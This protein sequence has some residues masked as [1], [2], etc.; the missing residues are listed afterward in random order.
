MTKTSHDQLKLAANTVRGLTMDAVEKANSG[1]PGMPM[2]MADAAV[3]LWLEHL[4]YSPADPE[5][6]GRDRFVLSAGH[7][8][9]LL[10]SLLHLAGY[11]LDLEQ[12]K[13]FRQLHSRTPG[14]PEHGE[15]VG[16]ET[17]TGPL[18]QGFGNGVGMALAARMEAAR[19]SCSLLETRVFGI[20]SDGDLMEGVA[21]EAASIAGHLGLSNLV[22][23]YDDNRITIDGKTEITFSEDVAQRFEG[24]G[25]RVL[26]ADGHDFDSVR[27][28]LDAAIA[29]SRKP[30]LIVCR[31]HI[32]QG[33]PNKANTSGAHG[34][35]LGA[36]EVAATK[37]A[38]GLP[39]QAFWVPDE[40]RKLFAARAKTNE[41]ARRGWNEKLEQW[42][43]AHADQ[44]ALHARF[45]ERATPADLLEQLVGAVG[46][47]ADA[48][49]NLSGAVI[50]KAADLVPSLVGGAADLDSS[51]K[52]RI[53]ASGA[54]TRDDYAGRNIHFGVREHGM[55]AILNGMALQGG[56]LP[57]GSTFLVFSDYM[58]PSIRL[59]ALM[60][61]PITFV[62]THDSLMLGED[63]PTHQP[64]EHLA[65]L[66]LIPNLHVFRPADGPEVAA[67]WAHALR[68]RDGPV[69]MALTR[70]TVPPL[71]RPREFRSA[72][73]L[74]GGYTVLETGPNPCAV[75]VA[76]GAEVHVT[77]EAARALAN[78][79]THL[80][81]VSMPCLELF[82]GQPVAYRRQLLG[83]GIP[84]L[85]VEM[86][87]PEGGTQLTGSVDRVIGVA[88]FGASA[89][90]EALADYFGFTSE[91]IAARLRTMLEGSA[92][93]G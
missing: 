65:A 88:R 15:T 57:M 6:P 30:A 25:W 53:K 89:P 38:L 33:S 70:Q 3:V 78:D 58:R 43:R 20:V 51:T 36:D 19:F 11:D 49:R 74:R 21:N 56:C 75:V 44:A 68:R 9:M 1:H 73:I 46:T 37:K 8:S 90:A 82:L 92:V 60:R 24:L 77:M 39:A 85:A 32:A 40:V 76:T 84:I 41:D 59:A 63:G 22:Y 48:T 86:G 61:L 18:G 29:E 5:W 2:G 34:A 7:G 47:K 62:F 91:K 79:G 14:H 50:Q 42:K 52:T 83:D 45:R 54:V 10:Y 55:G 12:L 66:R 16:V 17:T 28:A 31:T 4:R 23:L 93:R 81:V 27:G 13:N 35:P 87:R 69:A 72:D 71:A 64:I 26:R 80:R 67:G